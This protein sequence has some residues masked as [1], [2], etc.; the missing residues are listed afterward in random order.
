MR[1]TLL[2]NLQARLKALS[3][4][5]HFFSEANMCQHYSNI[6]PLCLCLSPLG[7]CCIIYHTS[8]PMLSQIGSNSTGQD[9]GLEPG[10]ELPVTS[11]PPN[12][13]IAIPL[14]CNDALSCG[15]FGLQ[16]SK[17]I[18]KSRRGPHVCHC[19]YNNWDPLHR[20]PRDLA[21]RVLRQVYRPSVV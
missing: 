8:A 14:S 17:N 20:Y 12:P 9:F 6:S 18:R 2:Q 5:A 10:G 15:S 7:V 4:L 16:A 11:F 19:S 1:M 21:D 13:F 3:F